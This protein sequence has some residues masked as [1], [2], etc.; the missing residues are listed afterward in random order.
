MTVDVKTG[1]FVENLENEF[2]LIYNNDT[3]LYAGLFINT[4][5]RAQRFDF[6]EALYEASWRKFEGFLEKCGIFSYFVLI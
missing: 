5:L 6:T 4:T 1:K 2:N 3:D